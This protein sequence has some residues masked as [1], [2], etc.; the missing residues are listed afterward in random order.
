MRA[1]EPT[2]SSGPPASLRAPGVLLGMGLG[3]FVDGIVL[4]QILRWHHMLSQTEEY[5]PTTLD[6]LQANVVADGLF[7]AGTWLLVV[8]GLALLWRSVHAGGWRHRTR[9]LVGWMAVGWGAFNLIEG[10]VNHHLLG[11]HRVRPDSARPL[12]WDLG[13]LAL[14]ALLVGGGWLLQRSERPVASS[15]QQRGRSAVPR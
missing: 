9:A 8:A 12:V 2:P 1:T 15:N 10:V 5:H 11:V 14:G 6:N 3:G 4:H 13:F 7:H